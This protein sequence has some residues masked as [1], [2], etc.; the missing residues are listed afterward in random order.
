MVIGGAVAV[1]LVVA[2]V[3]ILLAGQPPFYRRAIAA[4]TGGPEGEARARRLVTKVS[5]LHAALSR[6]PARRDG[7]A[8]RWEAAIGAEELSDERQQYEVT[9]QIDSIRILV[10]EW[11]QA[12]ESQ[13]KVT[14]ETARLLK[15]WRH[16]EFQG[17]RPCGCQIEAAET[18]ALP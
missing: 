11:R 3:A 7:E 12:P 1:V 17:I 4:G 13:W 15:H 14:Q 2:V 18:C 5:A 6:P 8:G 16:H 9:Q 10:E